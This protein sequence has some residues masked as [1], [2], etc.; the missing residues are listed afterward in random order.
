MWLCLSN[1]FISIVKNAASTEE[2]NE[3]LIRSRIREHLSFYFP[4]HEIL[5]NKG[6]DYK[7]RIMISKEAFTRWLANESRHIDYTNFKNSVHDKTLKNFYFEIWL[8]G[9]DLLQKPIEFVKN[10]YGVFSNYWTNYG[11]SK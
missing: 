5:E 4:Q 8:L 11:L 6:T 3:L 10:K 7:Y 9:C 2:S 1:G